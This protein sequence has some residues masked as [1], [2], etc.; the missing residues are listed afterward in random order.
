MVYYH[1]AQFKRTFETQKLERV[2]LK[3]IIRQNDRARFD[4]CFK[5]MSLN[6]FVNYTRS[7]CD[8]KLIFCLNFQILPGSFKQIMGQGFFQKL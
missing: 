4:F 2:S 8:Y 6:L 7:P 1:H 3:K 5:S